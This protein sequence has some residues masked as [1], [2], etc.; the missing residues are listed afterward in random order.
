MRILFQMLALISAGAGI[1]LTTRLHPPFGFLTWILKI[2]SSLFSPVVSLVGLISAFA[3]WLQK[4]PVSLLGGGIGF[5]L[6][7]RHI[8]KISRA[9]PNFDPVFGMHWEQK[10]PPAQR[11]QM[12]SRPWSL[13]RIGRI[14]RLPACEMEINIPFW[15][16]P[17]KERQLMC[18]IWQPPPG[19]P[20]S[21]AVVI[22]FHSSAWCLVDKDFGTRPLF[23]YLAGQGYVVMDVAYRLCRETS[24]AGMT[25]DV[26][27]AIAWIKDNAKRYGIDSPRII[28]FGAS[29]RG[30]IALLAAYAQQE[31]AFIPAELKD[32]DL[33]VNAVVSYYGPPD[34][35]TVRAHNEILS[36]T[37]IRTLKGMGLGRQ[38]SWFA[39]RIFTLVTAR[40]YEPLTEELFEFLQ[41][42]SLI[43]RIMG[44]SPG[45]VPEQY[46]LVSPVTYIHPLCPPTL[47]IH[48]EHDSLVPA[49]STQDF[50]HRLRK[51]N[52]SVVYLELPQTDHAFDL[53]LSPF[54]PAM[55]ASIYTLERFLALV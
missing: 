26:F 25:H 4:D 17:G 27:R 47:L 8:Q 54:S 35:R 44:G 51:A 40:N 34:M 36:G 52:V 49:Y 23:E 3:G 41:T 38:L 30:Q 13:W 1:L 18:D 55:Q 19:A 2:L 46:R 29:A 15:K 37:F 12:L 14:S 42:E 16:I 48:G 50:Y 5:W 31:P 24:I 21:G 39:S 32:R 22:Y 20:R 43:D 28:L 9:Y 6:S 45:E 53:I 11:E 33:S 10:I 7:R